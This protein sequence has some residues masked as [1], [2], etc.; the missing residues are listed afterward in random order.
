MATAAY[1][2]GPHRVREWRPTDKPMAG[3][4]WI[5]TIP[6]KETREYVKNI[7]TYQAIYKYRMGLVAN[8]SDDIKAVKPKSTMPIIQLPTQLVKK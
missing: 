2:A 8:L 3:D 6:F 5:E 4:I 7:M 1:N